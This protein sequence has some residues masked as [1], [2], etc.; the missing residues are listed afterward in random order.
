MASAQTL[1]TNIVINAR[2]GSGFSEVGNTLTEL[3]SIVDGASQA[4]IG[5]GSE[6]LNVYKDFQKSMTEA[7]GVYA[8]QYGAGSQQLQ[9]VMDGL[10]QAATEW[11]AN[12]IFHTNDVANAI[13]LAA[14]AGWTYENV[15]EGIPAAMQLAQAGS[16]DLSEA[17]GYITT[18]AKAAGIE[19]EDIP[20][21]I[22]DWAYAAASSRTDIEKMG[23]SMDKMGYTMRLAG[24]Q[25]DLLTMLAAL[26][27]AGTT[28]SDA[29]TLL[30]NVM[31]RL[32]APTGKA[33]EAMDSLGLSGEEYAAAVTEL[34]E[35]L[36]DDAYLSA[37]ESLE[38]MGFS[39]YTAEG[40][41]KPMVQVFSELN[42]VMKE[43]FGDNEQEANA[44][45][46][47]IFPTR[48]FAGAS[49][50]L[51]AAEEGWGGLFE[52][53]QSGESAG[54][55]Q[56]LQTL[57]GET[58]YGQMEL[59]ES[60]VERLKQL[61]GEELADEWEAGMSQIGEIVDSIAGLD[62][63]GML[64]ALVSGA[65]VIATAGP[66]LMIAAGAFRII[67]TLLSSKAA[68]IG[69]GAIFFASIIKS[70]NELQAIELENQ[71]GTGNLDH[72]AISGYLETL[73]DS[74]DGAYEKVD[75]FRQ[76]V[77][78]SIQSYNT[79]SQTFT[80][81]LF[82][83]MLT[84]TELSDEDIEK[85]G[86][87]AETMKN[88]VLDGLNADNNAANEFWAAFFGTTEEGS[89]EEA[90]LQS[91]LS[92][93]TAAYTQAE[94]QAQAIGEGLREAMN[95]AFADGHVS[96]EE[97]Q[98]ILSYITS[99]NEAIAAAE[100]EVQSRE[101]RIAAAAKLK[102]GQN[103][104]LDETVSIG[105]EI[106]ESRDAAIERVDEEYYHAYGEYVVAAEDEIARWTGI[107]DSATNSHTAIHAQQQIERLQAELE[108]TPEILEKQHYQNIAEAVQ[109]WNETLFKLWDNKIEEGGLSDPYSYLNELTTEVLSGRLVPEEAAQM[110]S[111]AVDVQQKSD[112]TNVLTRWI[113]NMG[114]IDA[115]EGLITAYDEMGNTSD[116]NRL[117]QALAMQ[118]IAGGMRDWNVTDND[119]SVL[120]FLFG[121]NVMTMGSYTGNE[122]SELLSQIVPSTYSVEDAQRTL[123]L[124]GDNN[125]VAGFIDLLGTITSDIETWGADLSASD[126]ETSLSYIQSNLE[127]LSRDNMV[128]PGDKTGI[129]DQLDQMLT[130]IF[131]NYDVNRV[132]ADVFGST[133]LDFGEYGKYLGAYQLI[134]GGVNPEDYESESIDLTINPD[135]EEFEATMDAL[136]G[137]HIVTI[138]DPDTNELHAAIMD[139]DGNILTEYV[140]GNV[141]DL[142]R[143]I[144]SQDGRHITVY[145]DSISTSAKYAEGGRATTASIFGEA[146]PEWAI[147]EE[148]SERTAQLL[149][150]ARKASGFSWAE[151]L[152]RTGGLNANPNNSPTTIV[153]SPTINAVDASGVDQ[154]LRM[155]E[156][157]LMKLMEE[158]QIIESLEVYA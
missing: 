45:L 63:N 89:E 73:T 122:F 157:R 151:I 56:Y 107:R 34:D 54:Y 86:N 100:K 2:T 83:A 42:E 139:E 70:L 14:H 123:E 135:T 82:T 134:T 33:Q 131:S 125:S 94:A 97:Y 21:F 61:V 141:D 72:G 58:L 99:Y 96:E 75:A 6:S 57:M 67:G 130:G 47:S 26:G 68:L 37:Y 15:L 154:A 11:A 155:S 30:R 114:G 77:D 81:D 48:V 16:I 145:T 19:F 20:G 108:S 132:V 109:P 110:F 148:H 25:E 103:A 158:R 136:D 10:E 129:Y 117:F 146:G 13:D 22:D 5:F 85:F 91:V 113:Q 140:L 128:M 115:V 60:K 152:A 156:E 38:N 101:D 32:V 142:I 55:G 76:A 116:A 153:F 127:Q 36:G 31:L 17:V 120:K 93:T 137:Q 106:Q 121:E 111:D 90:A 46:K 62:D 49:A 44:F 118:Q 102:R 1:T 3:S 29:G 98:N 18:S 79:A 50:L 35:L 126:L 104:S 43:T 4:L 133:G 92:T 69:M 119:G 9:T 147:P 52:T 65:E 40:K 24:S 124:L 64:G 59:F 71:F 66:G 12:T 84:E 74:F 80:G 28:G 23:Q 138:A 27:D 143:K 39:A 105:N 78:D 7:E 112:L 150:S 8:R 95:A 144:N 149:D 88:A 41:L 53:L 87:L 51:G